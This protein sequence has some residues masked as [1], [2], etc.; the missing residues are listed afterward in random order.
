MHQRADARFVVGGE[1]L[2]R[3]DEM[4]I[5]AANRDDIA[6]DLLERV[7]Q[8]GLTEIGERRSTGKTREVSHGLD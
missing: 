2:M 5:L 4:Q 1:R 6:V 3:V 7:E 8:A